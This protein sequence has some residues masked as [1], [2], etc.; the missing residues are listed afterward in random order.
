MDRDRYRY[1]NRY[2]HA[3]EPLSEEDWDM[4]DTITNMSKEGKEKGEEK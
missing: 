2:Y 3:Q 4:S 1:C